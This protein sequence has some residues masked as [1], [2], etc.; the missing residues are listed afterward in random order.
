MTDTVIWIDDGSSLPVR[1]ELACLILLGVAF[2]GCL[3]VLLVYHATG[4]HRRSV[5]SI[6]VKRVWCDAL[7]L[8]GE[9]I[10]IK[11]GLGDR[12]FVNGKPTLIFQHCHATGPLPVAM[13]LGSALWFALFMW[14]TVAAIRTPFVVRNTIA[15]RL[16]YHAI[17]LVCMVAAIVLPTYPADGGEY[18]AGTEWGANEVSI[19]GLV[20]HPDPGIS[21]YYLTIASLPSVCVVLLSSFL[22][23]KARRSL[24]SGCRR[25]MVKRNQHLVRLTFQIGAWAIY[26]A[27]GVV[28]FT[29]RTLVVDVGDDYIF[30]GATESAKWLLVSIAYDSLRGLVLDPLLLVTD[31]G[32]LDGYIG[33]ADAE[34]TPGET[35]WYRIKKVF[36]ETFRCESVS[37]KCFKSAI[38]DGGSEE[39]Q[40]QQSAR[41]DVLMCVMQG[42]IQSTR[43]SAAS[44]PLP[45]GESGDVSAVPD[46]EGTAAP[47]PSLNEVAQAASERG[48]SGDVGIRITAD[49]HNLT[50]QFTSSNN[51]QV[52]SLSNDS[53]ST[54][55]RRNTSR[56]DSRSLRE[57]FNVAMSTSNSSNP[58]ILGAQSLELK[59][60]WEG[61]E[62]SEFCP[63]MFYWIR[64]QIGISPE[65]YIASI[66]SEDHT[67]PEMAE[68]FTE[69][70][71]NSF[72]YFT[73]DRRFMVKT[74]TYDD[75]ESICETV[76]NYAMHLE[77]YPESL[78]NRI[79]GCYQLKV[80]AWVEEPIYIIVLLNLIWSPSD[81]KPALH[82]YFDL[83]GSYTDRQ[84]LKDPDRIEELKRIDS[85]GYKSQLKDVDLTNIELR[86]RL[87]PENCDKLLAQLDEDVE[88]LRIND[89]MDC[90]PPQDIQ[91]VSYTHLT[92]PTKR[93][94]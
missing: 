10:A 54:S 69:G 1:Y 24:A 29:V 51:S 87:S 7:L 77:E 59:T 52:G 27:V 5:Y 39:F 78:L 22:L 36:V 89:I 23:V 4:R 65:D 70:R 35:A 46:Q 16:S 44:V 91:P 17:V 64:Q 19:C 25:T 61:S 20:A 11:V 74:C 53:H 6:T 66:E 49:G 83:K 13:R 80:D 86:P 75:Y 33:M 41:E 93:I 38:L 28:L 82:C 48:M 9:M 88:W 18:H 71:S 76:W 43:A 79:V 12:A 37:I 42:V 47:R 60:A 21:P 3:L 14:D 56:R 58:E 40:L 26:Y 94:V 62:F 85:T 55:Q 84:G 45:G 31:L 81:S 67:I 2:V 50:D 8:A 32:I 34:M 63:L 15:T 57:S 73:W 72:F 68:R 30:D 92:L 90:D